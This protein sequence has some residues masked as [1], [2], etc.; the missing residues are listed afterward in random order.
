MTISS[1]VALNVNG[2][3][4]SIT[5]EAFLEDIEQNGIA[6]CEPVRRLATLPFDPVQALGVYINL[7]NICRTQERAADE[8]AA[9]RSAKRVGGVHLA[10]INDSIERNRHACRFAP[11]AGSDG[12]SVVALDDDPGAFDALLEPDKLVAENVYYARRPYSLPPEMGDA[13]PKTN[14]LEDLSFHVCRGGRRLATVPLSLQSDGIARWA[15]L[16][17]NYGAIP[18]RIHLAVDCESPSKT[19][20]F[21]LDYLVFLMRSHGVKEA[22]L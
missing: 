22:V 21:V 9:L 6:W 4:R 15:P 10:D 14:N 12:Y 7:A 2:S 11:A 1:T 20:N 16:V 13:L 5:T 8:L 19:I 3:S 17:T 18:A